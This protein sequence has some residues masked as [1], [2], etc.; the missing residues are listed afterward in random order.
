[1]PPLWVADPA[2]GLTLGDEG[3]LSSRQLA[4]FA[5]VKAGRPVVVVFYAI[6]RAVSG[7]PKMATG[8]ANLVERPMPGSKAFIGRKDFQRLAKAVEGNKNFYL[9]SETRVSGAGR[10]LRA[11]EPAE[12]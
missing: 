7:G 9:L 3:D 4:R 8:K 1:M 12:K 2:F 11:T 5:V 10:C 6:D